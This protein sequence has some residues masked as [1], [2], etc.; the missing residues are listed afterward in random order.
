MMISGGLTTWD[1]RLTFPEWIRWTCFC[2]FP[3][4]A[5]CPSPCQRQKCCRQILG[6]PENICTGGW[7]NN[8][9]VYVCVNTVL[10]SD[11]ISL[12]KG[13]IHIPTVPP[14]AKLNVAKNRFHII[15][16]WCHF[17]W[18]AVYTKCQ[19]QGLRAKCGLPS[20]FMWPT[21]ACLIL[22]LPYNRSHLT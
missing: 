6:S 4:S 16:D 7:Y 14:I 11:L 3:G 19:T 17:S 9:D 21:E 20:H 13:T 15:V 22:K 2:W 8:C 18:H 1:G 5:R 10:L 12:C